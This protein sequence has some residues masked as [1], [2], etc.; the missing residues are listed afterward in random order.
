MHAHTI[1]R[2]LFYEIAK[3]LVFYLYYILMILEILYPQK[4]YSMVFLS[5]GCP[6]VSDHIIMQKLQKECQMTKTV[7]FMNF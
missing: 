2:Y 5:F 6:V 4:R 7:K 1:I 3:L